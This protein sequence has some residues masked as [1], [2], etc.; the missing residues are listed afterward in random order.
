MAA[1]GSVQISVVTTKIGIQRKKKRVGITDALSFL[2]VC[3]EDVAD[4]GDEFFVA[5][6]TM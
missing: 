2:S 5:G 1:T 6:E 4:S 3:L